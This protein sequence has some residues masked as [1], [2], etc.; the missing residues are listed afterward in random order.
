M[1]EQS[2]Y[3]SIPVE[4]IME[5][6]VPG[7]DIYTLE[8]GRYYL[9]VK[10]SFQVTRD[11]LSKD[12]AKRQSYFFIRRE[13]RSNYNFYLEN[14][15]S[16]IL[17]N[18]YLPV[19]KKIALVY[20]VSYSIGRELF[21]RSASL[22]SARLNR[23]IAGAMSFIFSSRIPLG[24]IIRISE[25]SMHTFNHML[26]CAIHAAIFFPR[27]GVKDP[28]LL[29][30]LTVGAFLHDIGKAKVDQRILK[31][32]DILSPM[33]REEMNRHPIYGVRFLNE[34]L[35]IQDQL[36]EEMILNHHER[37]DGSGFPKGKRNMKI[38]ERAVAIIDVY[39]R[40][41]YKRS[42]VGQRSPKEAIKTII[43]EEGSGIDQN[44]LS[45]FSNYIN[46]HFS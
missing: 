29:K 35:G 13:D 39:E 22:N 8:N 11:N 23:F 10:A 24:E 14:R 3:I 31:K 21:S 28:K 37:L 36:I 9:F 45:H 2:E 4:T 18:D 20:E 7:F 44:L 5:G 1:N 46:D 19:D 17:K 34:V 41:T 16:T 25:K 38:H 42:S 43:S 27:I 12:Y 26:H 30:R 40:L 32:G 6:E 33:E 15:L